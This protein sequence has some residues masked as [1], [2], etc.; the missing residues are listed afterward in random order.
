MLQKKP[1]I[2]NFEVLDDRCIQGLQSRCSVFWGKK[3]ILMLE[4]L[5]F[6]ARS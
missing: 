6:S 3:M 4:N 2:V 1:P 5:S